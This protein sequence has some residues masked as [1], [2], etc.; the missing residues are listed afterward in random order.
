[1]DK[2]KV[3]DLAKL[4]RIDISDNEAKKLSL[5]FDAILG[6]VGEVK[7]VSGNT[8]TDD[9]VSKNVMRE[10]G[11]THESG[12]YTEDILQQAPSREGDYIKVKKIL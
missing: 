8:D 2:E 5:E 3:L 9:F 12:L 6:Y 11:N 7:G 4:A 10:D 1:M